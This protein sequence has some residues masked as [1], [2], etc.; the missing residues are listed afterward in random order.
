M[1]CPSPGGQNVE[2][3]VRRDGGVQVQAAPN[4]EKGATATVVDSIDPGA[5]AT[6]ARQNEDRS[7]ERTVTGSG[8]L[9]SPDIVFR[10]VDAETAVVVGSAVDEREG[11]FMGDA[12]LDE[13]SLPSAAS[14]DENSTVADPDGRTLQ[15]PLS[16]V[17]SS[18]DEEETSQNG[19]LM[20][21]S[22]PDSHQRKDDDSKAND[23]QRPA[24]PKTISPREAPPQPSLSISSPPPGIGVGS[25][26]STQVMAAQAVRPQVWV[27]LMGAGDSGC[28]GM[29]G[30]QGFT[31][32]ALVGDDDW[33]DWFM[34]R[35]KPLNKGENRSVKRLRLVRPRGVP[36]KGRLE[37]VPS[38]IAA[39]VVYGSV[40]KISRK[41]GM[42]VYAVR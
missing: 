1:I 16:A 39:K 25:R 4:A 27:P 31:T 24:S 30:V 22:L 10:C 29:I 28:I 23:N 21:R 17:P 42:P 11:S 33:R 32:G 12:C 37:R 36:D 3:V 13:A 38:G 8:Q 20:S 41:R 2:A 6:S 9:P 14:A 35:M 26:Y 34:H 5:D 15:G 18:L 40:E 7:W 19:L